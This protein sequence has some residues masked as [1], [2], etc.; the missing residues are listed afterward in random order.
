MDERET[1][2]ARPLRGCQHCGEPTRGNW[3]SESCRR[4]EEHDYPEPEGDDD[5]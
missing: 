5:R 3:C 4:A 2:D 1:T